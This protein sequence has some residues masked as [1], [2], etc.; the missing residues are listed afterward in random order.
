MQQPENDDYKDLLPDPSLVRVEENIV[1]GTRQLS[2][3]DRIA[4]NDSK[5]SYRKYSKQHWV[6]WLWMER[7]ILGFLGEEDNKYHLDFFN[8]CLVPKMESLNDRNITLAYLVY[9]L[10]AAELIGYTV[11]WRSKIR[12]SRYTKES[13]LKSNFNDFIDQLSKYPSGK[14]VMMVKCILT[15]GNNNNN[16]NDNDNNDINNNNKWDGTSIEL[17]D[18]HSIYPSII[19]QLKYTPLKTD[20]VNDLGLAQSSPLL[21]YIERSFKRTFLFN[22]GYMFKPSEDDKEFVV[23]RCKELDGEFIYLRASRKANV[24]TMVVV[25]DLTIVTKY[26]DDEAG[27]H[28]T[29]D[30]LSA[31]KLAQPVKI[32]RY[33]DGKLKLVDLP[34]EIYPI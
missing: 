12:T 31:S 17:V 16:N 26:R 7:C 25:K 10:S 8:N 15:D 23:N 19:E 29:R 21:R 18:F 6:R 32:L 14:R 27:A 4:P 3:N 30:L 2:D 22:N 28:L 5:V 20:R 13:L 9:S 34:S 11:T 1:V 33:H 24:W